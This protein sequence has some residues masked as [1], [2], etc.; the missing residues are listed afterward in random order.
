MIAKKVG[1]NYIFY[2]KCSTNL[3]HSIFEITSIR[4]KLTEK[5]YFQLEDI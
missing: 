1:Q 4:I 2:C 5:E 3:G